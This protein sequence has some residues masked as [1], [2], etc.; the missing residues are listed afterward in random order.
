MVKKR[1]YADKE[2]DG[3]FNDEE[4]AVEEEDVPKNKKNRRDKP[5][6]HEGIDHWCGYELFG[7]GTRLSLTSYLHFIY[8]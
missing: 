7:K 4:P 5:W 6:D 1:K 3:V 8:N 2:D